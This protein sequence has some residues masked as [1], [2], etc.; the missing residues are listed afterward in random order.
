MGS[1]STNNSLQTAPV[2]H[3]AG[4]ESTSTSHTVTSLDESPSTSQAVV[5]GGEGGI[6]P[7]LASFIAQTVQAALAAERSAQSSPPV[8][9]TPPQSTAVEVPNSSVP[10]SMASSCFGGVLSSLGSSASNFLA[11]GTGLSQQGRPAFSLDMVVPSFVSTFANPLMSASVSSPSVHSLQNSATRDVADRSAVLASPL[12]DQPFIVG[13]GFSPVPAKL[14]A[15]IVAGKYIDLSDL[16]AANLVQR[17]P[18]PQLLFDG[19]LVLTSQ[20]K[21]QQRRIEDIASWMEAFAIFSLILVSHFPNRWKD[22]MQY[23][24]LIL[25]TYRHFSGRVWPTYDQAFREH[26]AA[27]RLADWSLMNVQLFNFHSASSSARSTSLVSSN[28]SPEPPGSSSSVIY[29]KS[30]NKERCT[31]PFAFCRYSHRCSVCSGVHRSISCP[32]QSAKERSHESKR[33]SRSPSA[34]RSSSRAKAP[35]T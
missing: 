7:A 9:T 12:L 16:L 11:V 28:D 14:V 34:S 27:S 6:S 33:R 25:R 23:Q 29:C 31:A 19:R 32:N 3:M 5:C 1:R 26:A 30:W 35:R 24:L 2:Y 21:R 22:L 18:E 13:P 17:E 20:P 15:Q 8:S 4:G 10:V